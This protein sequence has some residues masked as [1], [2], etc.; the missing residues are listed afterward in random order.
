MEDKDKRGLA[1]IVAG[2]ILAIAGGAGLIFGRNVKQSVLR[3]SILII[4]A[5]SLGSG[6]YLFVDGVTDLAV[7]IVGQYQLDGPAVQTMTFPGP[8][9]F[10]MSL[11][12]LLK[13]QP[14]LRRLRYACPDESKDFTVYLTRF[15]VFGIP[16][17]FVTCADGFKLVVYDTSKGFVMDAKQ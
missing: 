12:P 13:Q 10:E 7:G 4:S 15:G 5:L 3:I 14:D 8:N 9:F 1:K 2:L 11:Q 6:L 16:S 17:K